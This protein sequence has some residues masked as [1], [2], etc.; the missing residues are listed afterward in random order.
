LYVANWEGN[1]DGR[2]FISV[3]MTKL[4]RLKEILGPDIPVTD[5]THESAEHV[6][7]ML[8]KIPSN[9]KQYSHMTAPQIIAAT[10]NED[11]ARL[12]TK[13]RNDHLELYSRVFSYAVMHTNETSIQFDPFQGVRIIKSAKERK[14]KARKA[15][16]RDQLRAIF[17]TPLHAKP[18]TSMPYRY[19][20]PLLALFT[21]ARRGELSS[22]HLE[23]IQQIDGIW[24]IDFNENTSK[25]RVKSV[26][27]FRRTPIHPA[28]VEYGFLNYV[29]QLRK[30]GE[31]RLF[32]DL[33]K[34]TDKELY[35]RAIGE[36]M[37]GSGTT[38]PGFLAKLGIKGNKGEFVFHSFRHVTTTELRR[39]GADNLTIEQICGR[40]EGQKSVGQQSYTEDDLLT[41]LHQ[42][43]SKLDFSIELE[44]VKA[45]I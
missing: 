44:A 18:D 15:F 3:S 17:S 24:I 25:K 34:W 13:T 35:G 23:D 4:R 42:A 31:T 2:Q 20:T 36:W 38:R 45:W 22:L 30:R 39:S 14:K 7:N 8:A 12:G 26:N 21:G 1:H 16:S 41:T 29:D 11:V 32:P 27:G 9:T 10:Q 5:I 40:S 37:N 6:R 43:L 28:L 33:K 19:W